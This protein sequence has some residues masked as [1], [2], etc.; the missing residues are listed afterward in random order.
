MAVDD[1]DTGPGPGRV[2]SSERAESTGLRGRSRALE[3]E[4]GI[5]Q[6]AGAH[7]AG[8]TS[9]WIS[10]PTGPGTGRGRHPRHGDLPGSARPAPVHDHGLRVFGGIVDVRDRYTACLGASWIAASSSGDRPLPSAPFASD[11]LLDLLGQLSVMR[12]GLVD[13]R[14]HPGHSLL[15]QRSTGRRGSRAAGRTRGRTAP[16]GVLPPGY[17]HPGGHPVVRCVRG[18]TH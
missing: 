14:A 1:V 18:S 13:E 12:V 7:V 10:V 16:G 15:R 6:R 5:I 17:V 8:R 9:S 3:R 11:D 4:E 2:T